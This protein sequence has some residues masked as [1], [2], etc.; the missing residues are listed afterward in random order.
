MSIT[1]ENQPSEQNWIHWAAAK[2]QKNKVML[3][4]LF[5]L[6]SLFLFLLMQMSDNAKWKLHYDY[7]MQHEI[8]VYQHLTNYYQ[9]HLSWP[10]I[11]FVLPDDSKWQLTHSDIEPGNTQRL[12]FKPMTFGFQIQFFL[13]PDGKILVDSNQLRTRVD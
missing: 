2:L 11:K 13:H 8:L 1:Q 6:V 12:L 9:L 3:V 10:D 5:L 7:D 4:V